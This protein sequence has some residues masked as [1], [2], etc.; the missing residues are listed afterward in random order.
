MTDREV[1]PGQ[2]EVV[3]G[4]EEGDLVLGVVLGEQAV[5]TSSAVK[6]R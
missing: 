5:E 2:T 1:H 6:P 3:L 4:A